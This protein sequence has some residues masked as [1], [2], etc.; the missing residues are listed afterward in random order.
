MDGNHMIDGTTPYDKRVPIGN[1]PK[2]GSHHTT[3]MRQC[4][5]CG[6]LT[7]LLRCKNDGEKT[8]PVWTCDECC[9]V[10]AF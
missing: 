6:D 5:E 2:C 7:E 1:C 4:S 8:A 10:W 9:H 3:D